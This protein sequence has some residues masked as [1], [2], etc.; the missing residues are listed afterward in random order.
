MMYAI[1]NCFESIYVGIST[2]DIQHKTYCV[3]R[4]I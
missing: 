3:K 4:Q 2:Y 1:K